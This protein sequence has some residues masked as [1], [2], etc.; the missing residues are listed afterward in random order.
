MT[1]AEK[2][3][4]E[5]AE[6]EMRRKEKE[7]TEIT[8]LFK[9]ADADSS[10]L[11]DLSELERLLTEPVMAAYLNSLGI[12]VEEARGL[13]KILDWDGSGSIDVEEFVTGCM[14]IGGAA[15]GVELAMLHVVLNSL[16]TSFTNFCGVVENRFCSLGAL[17]DAKLRQT[18]LTSL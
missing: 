11:V 6:K 3:R 17:I 2:S 9:S 8:A 5:L 14:R 7:A 10:G 12:Q 16:V 13:F 15:K 18:S 4:I 1:S